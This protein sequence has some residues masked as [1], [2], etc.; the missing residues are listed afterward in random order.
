MVILTD[1]S[2]MTELLAAALKYCVWKNIQKTAEMCRMMGFSY[3]CSFCTMSIQNRGFCMCKAEAEQV[4]TK[5]SS[6][7]RSRAFSA[8]ASGRFAL[9][10]PAFLSRS[11]CSTPWALISKT[12]SWWY[13]SAWTVQDSMI[14]HTDLGMLQCFITVRATNPT[15][16]FLHSCLNFNITKCW[17]HWRHSQWIISTVRQDPTEPHPHSRD[18]NNPWSL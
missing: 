17:A 18:N 8:A 4:V 3:C 9:P 6:K 14:F 1:E 12:S 16:S 2:K 15:R 5:D 11:D 13:I 10:A 7:N